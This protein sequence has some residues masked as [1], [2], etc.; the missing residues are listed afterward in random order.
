MGA[1]PRSV[2]I[3]RAI[4]STRWLELLGTKPQSEDQFQTHR[5]H[6]TRALGLLVGLKRQ[7]RPFNISV[8]PANMGARSPMETETS[9]GGSMAH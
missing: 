4:L 1:K 8:E 7:L 9:V 6:S 3:T 2:S 5:W